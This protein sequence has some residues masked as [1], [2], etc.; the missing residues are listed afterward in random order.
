MA[1]DSARGR[2][3]LFTG[4]SGSSPGPGTWEWDGTSWLERTSS[5]KPPQRYYAAMAYDS[6]RARTVLF[7]GYGGPNGILADTWEWDGNDWVERT[8][9]ASPPVR[10]DHAMAFDSTRGRVVLLGGTG[11][12]GRLSDTWEWDGST[13]VEHSPATRP[14]PRIYHDMVYDSARG[15]VVVFGGHRDADYYFDDTW[16]WD[17]SLWV[18]RKPPRPSTRIGH[19]MTYDGTRER[20]VLFGGVN[21][22][23][24][25]QDLD[26]TWEWDGKTKTWI[27][28]TP[29]TRPP[30]RQ[31]HE[32]AYDSARGR[33]VLFGNYDGSLR[34]TWEWDGDDWILRSPATSPPGRHGHGMVYDSARGRIVMFGGFHVVGQPFSDDTW[35][36]D[37]N[38]WVEHT[39][40]IRPAPRTDHGM[41]YDRARG[42]VV[43]FG[44][45]GLVDY[46]DT[47]EW[48]GTSWTELT[49]ATSPSPRSGH[50]MAYDEQRDRVVLFG[51]YDSSRGPLSE[52]W[53][54]D[55]TNWIEVPTATSPSTR[56]ESL[57]YDGATGRMMFV[58]ATNL[59]D[60]WH[61]GRVDSCASAAS[62]VAFTPGG[63][64][65]DTS[66]LA[67]LGAPDG[68][69]V[70]LGLG[71]SVELQFD[72]PVVNGAG[73]D[74]TVHEVGSGDIDESY[75]VEVSE[76]GVE[77]FFAGDCSGQDCQLDLG[78]AGLSSATHVKMADLLSNEGDP[79]GVAGADIDG[80]SVV[81][82]DAP[83][84]NAFDSKPARPPAPRPRR[85]G[86]RARDPRRGLRARATASSVRAR[87]AP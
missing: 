74:L 6:A 33:V 3:V 59:D 48:D 75:R 25:S 83:R 51:G 77:Y 50:V 81:A 70:S 11:S 64:T 2:T 55:G 46:G 49:P 19:D 14:G 20:V 31:W 69:A 66:A 60:M 4:C 13:W 15:R 61:Y 26:D 85:R 53:E 52:T 45:Y 79:A 41:V 47:W 72:P 58:G 5:T 86:R 87:R 34:D 82:C 62:V 39:P 36:W 38:D 78:R 73:A 17:G 43:L 1:Y 28:R 29:A 42:R 32:M 80:V 7:G 23:A 84:R 27:E 37:G 18:E 8:P 22:A 44:G 68:A 21:L 24:S 54:W 9:A 56:A 57:V 65:E 76:D 30:G 40:A 71:G 63:G 35:E 16:E 12:A 67:A 10:G